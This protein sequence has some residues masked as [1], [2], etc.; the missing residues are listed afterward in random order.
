M[1]HKC[2]RWCIA[3]AV[4]WM[5][6]RYFMCVVCLCTCVYV[7]VC[8]RVRIHVY[9]LLRT[10][11]HLFEGD[12]VLFSWRSLKKNLLLI[13]ADNIKSH[14]RRSLH[15]TVNGRW[16][17]REYVCGMYKNPYFI[18]IQNACVSLSVSISVSVCCICF[19]IPLD[20]LSFFLCIYFFYLFF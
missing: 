13:F 19:Y 5:N 20:F 6:P 16:C 18:I 10:C 17:I 8:V 14:R 15:A 11:F 3:D 1:T 7:Y 4:S 9:V 2:F 12:W